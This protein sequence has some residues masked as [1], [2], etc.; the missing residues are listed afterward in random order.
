MLIEETEAKSDQVSAQPHLRHGEALYRRG[1]VFGLTVAEIFI[2]LVFVLLLVFLALARQWQ[3]EQRETEERLE[4]AQAELEVL[5]PW[6]PVIEEF[7]APEEVETLRLAEARA[8]RELEALREVVEE[9]GEPSENRTELLDRLREAVDEQVAAQEESER[10]REELRVLQEK[11]VNPPC[12]YEKVPTTDGGLREK[13]FYT[14]NLAVFDDGIVVRKVE[15][16]PGGAED[17]G[18][19]TYALESE[20]LGLHQLPYDSPL[21]DAEFL[22]QFRDIQRAG[23]EKQV[24][25]Y[26]CIFW[27]RVWDRTSATAKERWKEVHLNVVQGLFGT[28]VV[29]EDPWV[30][31]G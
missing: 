5:Q 23:K 29:R 20:Q 30:G 10:I 24:R 22:N 17:D 25:S 15:T 11:G 3:S 19:G 7:E 9:S 6:K 16:P 1:A 14:F 31:A 13:P 8:K 21:S 27:V 2:L 12:W 4:S 28:Y 26:S 18:E